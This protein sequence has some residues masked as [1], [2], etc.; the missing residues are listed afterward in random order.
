M[1]LLWN[2]LNSGGINPKYVS[3][4]EMGFL[5]VYQNLSACPRVMWFSLEEHISKT[6]LDAADT[7]SV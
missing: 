7:N 2:N 6:A 5:V 4:T 3:V 1:R